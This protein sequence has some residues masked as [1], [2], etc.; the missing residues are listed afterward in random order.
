[1]E[2]GHPG[3]GV[4]I[5]RLSTVP[6]NRLQQNNIAVC[7][8]HGRFDSFH[9]RLR[10]GVDEQP[11][12]VDDISLTA[13]RLDQ[14]LRGVVSGAVDISGDAKRGHR[15]VGC[16]AS[17][18]DGRHSI[19]GHLFQCRVDTDGIS[20]R[21][22]DCCVALAHQTLQELRLNAQ[23]E[24]CGILE[25]HSGNSELPLG[26]LCR[27]LPSEKVGVRPLGDEGYSVVRCLRRTGQAMNC[28]RRRCARKQ[29]GEL[30]HH[31]FLCRGPCRRDC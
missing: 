25:I 12:Q 15:W 26:I 21:H 4:L 1:M 23:A 18:G 27:V 11:G 8:E 13:N 17:Q 5:A 20:W 29:E 30:V 14:A 31:I 10:I 19:G 16:A 22:T 9:A 7:F 28:K 2:A 24:L 6:G 3:N